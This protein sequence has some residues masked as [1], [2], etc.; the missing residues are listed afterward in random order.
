MVTVVEASSS[1]D[2]DDARR[3]MRALVEWGRELSVEDRHL[4]DRYFD[5]VSF[6]AELASLPGRYA[7]PAGCLL[8]AKEGGRSVGCVAMR[9]LEPG[10]CEMKRMFIEPEH[11]GRG[12]GKALATRLIE[13]ARASGY[14][15]MRLDTSRHQAPA[16][17]LY[18]KLGFQRR[19]AYYDAP[20]GSEG[21]LLFFEKDLHGQ[22]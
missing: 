19:S 14:D 10:V 12:I 15:V 8:L 20:E 3:L 13:V 22:P 21:F 18:Q 7:P 11:H 6:E 1:S 9:P 5:P 16:I 17:A 2:L 4:I